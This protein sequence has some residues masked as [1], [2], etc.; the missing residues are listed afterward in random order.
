MW[1]ALPATDLLSNRRVW[2]SEKLLVRYG[3]KNTENMPQN[4]QCG[5]CENDIWGDVNS[6]RDT[7]EPPS[8]N[9]GD[10]GGNWL[11]SDLPSE[12]EE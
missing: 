7:V 9:I 4:E 3:G 6:S 10:V 1:G 11:R 8:R 5:G 12:E 2:L